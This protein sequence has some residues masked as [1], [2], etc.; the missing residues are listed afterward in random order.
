MP[1]PL[2]FVTFAKR[3]SDKTVTEISK[4]WEQRKKTNVKKPVKKQKS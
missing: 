4:L 2:S 3:H 1:R